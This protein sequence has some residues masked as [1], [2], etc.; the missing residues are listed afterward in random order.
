MQNST[1]KLKS[2][3]WL[4]FSLLQ[5]KLWISG[6]LGL[7]KD[8]V[9]RTLS[10]HNSRALILI[11]NPN[12]YAFFANIKQH[13]FHTH[14]TQTRFCKPLNLKALGEQLMLYPQLWLY[15]TTTTKFFN[16]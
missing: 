14:K 4:G 8:C 3:R 15:Y 12:C 6:E 13:L 1:L 16:I 5:E 9:S 10:T 7:I 11:N 2:N